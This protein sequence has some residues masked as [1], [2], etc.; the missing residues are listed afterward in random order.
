M[1]LSRA[2]QALMAVGTLL[3]GLWLGQLVE[4][5]ALGAVAGFVGAVL[6]LASI[7]LQSPAARQRWPRLSSRRSRLSHLFADTTTMRGAL[8][9]E[10][11]ANAVDLAVWEPRLRAFVAD[12]WTRLGSIEP[13]DVQRLR[14]R[15]ADFEVVTQSGDRSPSV[16]GTRMLAHL[17]ILRSMLEKRMDEHP[18]E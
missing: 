6:V 1:N 2:P 16:W 8:K 4:E 9:R 12:F 5:P 17:E 3:A 15:I 14:L 13:D 18:I 11:K 10:Y 7:A